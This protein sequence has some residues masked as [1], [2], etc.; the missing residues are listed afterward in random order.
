M[1][2]STMAP[3]CQRSGRL[4]AACPLRARS[5]GRSRGYADT[6]SAAWAATTSLSVGSGTWLTGV[7]DH[8]PKLVGVHSLKGCHLAESRDF[9][10]ARTAGRQAS[11][12]IGQD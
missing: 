7:L 3:R 9:G 8:L 4:R 11:E 5:F 1:A 12:V 2:A 10:L 6:K